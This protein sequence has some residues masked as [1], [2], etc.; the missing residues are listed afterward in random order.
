MKSGAK[1]I[2]FYMILVKRHC[3]LSM[4]VEKVFLSAGRP[5]RQSH[6]RQ[7]ISDESYPTDRK[8]SDGDLSEM[9]CR[10]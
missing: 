5:I 1:W 9:T 7:V 2:C 4:Y 8:L 6:F 3:D 10:K